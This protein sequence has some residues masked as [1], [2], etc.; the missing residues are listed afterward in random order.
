MEK[1]STRKP[2]HEQVPRLEG[3]H[4]KRFNPFNDMSEVNSKY[5]F[6]QAPNFE[7]YSFREDL[8]KDRDAADRA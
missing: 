4:P 1:T 5:K 7:N 8:K 6:P 2:V 3:P